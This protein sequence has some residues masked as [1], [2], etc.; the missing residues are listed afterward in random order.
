MQNEPDTCLKRLK[1]K[2]YVRFY[3]TGKANGDVT[4]WQSLKNDSFALVLDGE[5][6]IAG[7]RMLEGAC[8]GE[9]REIL[10]PPHEAYGARNIA[11]HIPGNS[12]VIFNVTVIDFNT[13]GAKDELTKVTDNLDGHCRKVYSDQIIEITFERKHENGTSLEKETNHKSFT[14][15]VD[16]VEGF[17]QNG[18]VSACLVIFLKAKLCLRSFASMSPTKSTSR[19]RAL[20]IKITISGSK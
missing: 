12:V 4:F 19:Q 10:I 9:T 16:F 2:D 13:P 17:L 20:P 7:L 5:S 11:D 14:M 3:G 1:M 8:P 6:H 18:E 15:D